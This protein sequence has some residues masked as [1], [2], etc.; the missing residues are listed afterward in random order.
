MDVKAKQLESY[1]DML[2]VTNKNIICD[3]LRLNQVILNI[4][5]NAMKYT[6]SDG[7]I[8]VRVI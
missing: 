7:M 2:N 5:S 3:K 1:I 4:L 6:K 8:G